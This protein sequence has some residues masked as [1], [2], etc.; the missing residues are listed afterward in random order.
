MHQQHQ[1]ISVINSIISISALATLVHKC[2][3]SISPS[4]ASADQQHQC[5]GY[6]HRKRYLPI[7]IWS[8]HIRL[9]PLTPPVMLQTTPDMLQT[10]SD[11]VQIPPYIFLFQSYKLGYVQLSQNWY[12]RYAHLN[13]NL[14]IPYVQLRPSKIICQGVLGQV[15][16]KQQNP[17]YHIL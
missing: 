1:C 13:R 2:I 5:I 14:H 10:P 6:R 15:F 9:Y 17:T 3:R 11:M 7:Y 12:I 16:N 8:G 4:V